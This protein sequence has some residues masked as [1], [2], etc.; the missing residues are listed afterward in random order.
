[1]QVP[2]WVIVTGAFI[3][4]LFAFFIL[5]RSLWDVARFAMGQE[6]TFAIIKPDAVAARSTG[7]I[8][9][10]IEQEGFLIK[11]MKKIDL[12]KDQAEKFYGVHK[13]KDFFNDL[14]SFMTSGPVVVMVLEKVNA[15]KAWRDLMGS[16]DPHKAA[17]WTLRQLFG[18]SISQNAVHG[19]DSLQNAEKEIAF[20]F[21]E[22]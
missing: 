17:E 1:M 22:L 11:A 8:I 16:T 3:A 2:R 20:F 12:Q 18:T 7:K 5:F 6:R 14:V 13:D 19:S 15:V 4:G 9:D 10:R 21:P